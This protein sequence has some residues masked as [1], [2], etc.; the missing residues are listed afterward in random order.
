MGKKYFYCCSLPLGPGS[1]VN[2]GNWGRIIKTYTPQT[3][4][5]AWLFIRELIFEEVRR[6]F[7]PQKP[8]RFCSIF[9]CQDL[10]GIQEF[11]KVS[12]RVLDIIYEVEVLEE[13]LQ[14]HTGDWT[15]FSIQNN[16]TYA[17]FS[18]RAKLYWS[19]ENITKPEFVTVSS[20]K[21][22]KKVE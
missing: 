15:L 6:E 19:G 22:I 10:E 7:F 20:I 17:T 12:N 3:S 5:N 9:L 11:K 18:D 1:I 2:P 4:P 21:I 13:Q 16:D 14:A 8:S